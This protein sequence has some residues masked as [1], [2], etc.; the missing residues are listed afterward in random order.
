MF[1]LILQDAMGQTP[2]HIAAYNGNLD[3]LTFLIFHGADVNIETHDGLTPYRLA[4]AE[5][6]KE[7]AKL[8]RV[9]S[10]VYF[11]SVF[12]PSGC[13]CG[14]VHRSVTSSCFN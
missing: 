6:E 3:L 10:I 13:L 5:G 1:T 2:M 12:S 14:F 9:C 11:V 4:V 8:I 7:A